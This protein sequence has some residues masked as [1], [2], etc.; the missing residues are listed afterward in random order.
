[1]FEKIMI[2]V[3]CLAMGVLSLAPVFLELYTRY[4]GT[5]VKKDA[6]SDQRVDS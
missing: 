1:M 6:D 4:F 3:L 2:L 5:G